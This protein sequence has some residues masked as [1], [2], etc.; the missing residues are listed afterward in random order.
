MLPQGHDGP[1]GFRPPR[2]D[3]SRLKRVS[4]SDAQ[5]ILPTKKT[6]NY[7]ISY[8]EEQQILINLSL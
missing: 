6:K 4:T 3:Q 5:N 7:D 1:S 8:C 2:N